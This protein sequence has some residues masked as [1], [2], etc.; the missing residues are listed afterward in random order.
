MHQ[1]QRS[2]LIVEVFLSL[3]VHLYKEELFLVQLH[4]RDLA[5][6]F[7]DGIK[8]HVCLISEMYQRRGFCYIACIDL[9]RLMP[10]KNG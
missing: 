9:Y 4:G 5:V 8:V 2:I 7:I 3:G 1:L 10:E 6:P